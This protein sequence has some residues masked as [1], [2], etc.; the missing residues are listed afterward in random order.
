[1]F[2]KISPLVEM[3]NEKMTVEK[4]SGTQLPITK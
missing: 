4:M 1:M 2:S 3:T